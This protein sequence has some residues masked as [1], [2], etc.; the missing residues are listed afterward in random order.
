M[1][2]FKKQFREICI[3]NECIKEENVIN[4]NN[5]DNASRRQKR[6]TASRSQRRQIGRL[7][8]ISK[9]QF[10]ELHMQSNTYMGLE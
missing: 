6:Y 1:H 3:H 7:I 8:T 5:K 4:Y 10:K 2:S 9:N